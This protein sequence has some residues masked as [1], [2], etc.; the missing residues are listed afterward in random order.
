MH[1]HSILLSIASAVTDAEVITAV[2]V[3]CTYSY[4]NHSITDTSCTLSSSSSL[5][6]IFVTHSH[7]GSNGVDGHRAAHMFEERGADCSFTLPQQAQ[8]AEGKA[9]LTGDCGRVEAE[10]VE[11][12]K[13][14]SELAAAAQAKVFQLGGRVAELNAD[15]ERVSQGAE[16]TPESQATLESQAEL[17][18]ASGERF[19]DS[20]RAL[21]G[22]PAP[23]P[24]Q[25]PQLA[26]CQLCQPCHAA[27]GQ[28]PE[29]LTANRISL[30]DFFCIKELDGE[31]QA[32]LQLVINRFIEEKKPGANSRRTLLSMTTKIFGMRQC[33]LDHL[34]DAYN[35][36]SFGWYPPA[37]ES[38]ADVGRPGT[39][40]AAGDPGDTRSTAAANYMSEVESE[41]HSQPG[42]I[43]SAAEA[44]YT[45]EPDEPVESPPDSVAV[46][47]EV[48]VIWLNGPK[49]YQS[50]SIGRKH[51]KRERDRTRAKSPV[52][53]SPASAD[54]ASGNCA[55]K[56]KVFQ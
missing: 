23:A 39:D 28:D 3:T 15:V 13:S 21:L 37:S 55:S 35:N 7:F 26:P 34:L 33:Q 24:S 27:E 56:G 5:R 14:A 9:G 38:A 2:D 1:I 40:P 43:H 31:E 42:D 22:R 10:Q 44:L 48:C 4:Y 19:V 17:A 16:A 45:Q 18:L 32:L 50:H 6:F 47:C 29:Q 11:L 25:G 52:P 51:R 53:V 30:S 20:L 36:N 54:D 49:Q 12:A 8:S 46:Y 41:A